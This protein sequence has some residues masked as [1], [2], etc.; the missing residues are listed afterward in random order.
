LSKSKR[1]SESPPEFFADR[2]LG[3][4]APALLVEWGWVVHV[5]GDHFADDAQDV[6]DDEWTAYGL[7]NGWS[8]LT[9][10]ERISTQS[11]VR[12]LLERYHGCV[13][14]LDT[15]NLSAAAKAARL[16]PVGGSYIIALRADPVPGSPWVTLGPAP[17]A[18]NRGSARTA[19][20]GRR[21][22]VLQGDLQL[23]RQVDVVGDAARGLELGFD[24]G[25]PS[26]DRRTP[27]PGC[28]RG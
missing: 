6:G 26:D 10:D 24:H 12:D 3:R 20:R 18:S 22:H 13:H 19:R 17:T 7:R 27:T 28:R 9:Q 23:H 5:I 8:L 4:R 16:N 15:A 14:C 11:V 2:C 25:G 1:S 21:G